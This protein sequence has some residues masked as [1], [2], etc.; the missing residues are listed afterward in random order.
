M[1]QALSYMTMDASLKYLPPELL[2]VDRAAS[3]VRRLQQLMIEYEKTNALPLV[4]ASPLG[5]LKRYRVRGQPEAALAAKHLKLNAI[6]VLV[7]PQGPLPFLLPAPI[8]DNEPVPPQD[9]VTVLEQLHTAPTSITTPRQK[10]DEA[11]LFQ[12]SSKRGSSQQ[13]IAKQFGVS[14]SYVNNALQLIKLTEQAQQAFLEGRITSSQARILSYEKNASRQLDLLAWLRREKVSA[15]ALERAI[16]AK[17]DICT[18]GIELDHLGRRL[19]ARWGCATELH[20]DAQGLIVQA[21]PLKAQLTSIIA[22]VSALDMV[23]ELSWQD[24]GEMSQSPLRFRVTDEQA[25]STWIENLR[26]TDTYDLG[27]TV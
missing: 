25:F 14:R 26:L 19:S 7:L 15:R 6:W 9:S 4:Y 12:A 23:C 17:V 20:V 13:A 5:Q 10:L 27:V 21:N 2:S 22:D 1:C 18:E 11:M 3:D 16:Y 8:D 24:H